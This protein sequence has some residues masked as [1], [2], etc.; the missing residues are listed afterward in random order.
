MRLIFSEHLEGSSLKIVFLSSQS[1][2]FCCFCILLKIYIRGLLSEDFWLCSPPLLLSCPSLSFISAFPILPNFDS[3]LSNFSSLW[4]LSW[5]EDLVVK[6]SQGLNSVSRWTLW[7]TPC[8]HRLLAL[9]KPSPVSA[10]VL[11]WPRHGF[12]WIQVAILGFSSCVVSQT[13][14]TSLLF[15]LRRGPSGTQ[16]L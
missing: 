14:V 12:P 4:G 5:K 7:Q 2:P 13:P 1:S 6:N 3:F 16:A 10:T 15:L 11:R 9:T 8:A